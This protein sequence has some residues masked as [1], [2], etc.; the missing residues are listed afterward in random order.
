MKLIYRA[1]LMVVA[2]F[3]ATSCSDS[4]DWTPGPS[5]NDS[6]GVFFREMKKYDILIEADDS[7]ILPVT[8]GRLDAKDAVEVPLK[9]VEAPEGVT[10]PSSVAFAAGESTASFDIDCSGMASKTSG[11]ILVELDPGYGA[12]YGS[13]STS[14][15]LNV[16]VSGGW[17]VVADNLEIDYEGSS[18]VYA[19][20]TTKLY[21][22]EGT[23]RFKIPNFMHSGLDFV[24]TV[25]DKTASYPDVVPYTNAVWFTEVFPDE[26][27]EYE[28]WYFYDSANETYPEWSPDGTE[29]LITSAMF[30]GAGYT[31][32]GINKGKGAF[33]IST[34]YDNGKTGWTYVNLNFKAAFNPFE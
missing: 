34:D 17:I 30:Y 31:Y 11:K 16:S 24:F 29:P 7:R 2:G 15:A 20:E 26:T 27:D 5:D 3:V 9:V 4:D 1:L 13:G 14:L 25:S 12:L 19:P 10:I 21:V 18:I 28:C 23:E 32:I 33:T 22:L 6:K 8:M